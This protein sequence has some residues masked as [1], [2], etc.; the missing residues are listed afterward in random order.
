MV[1]LTIDGRKLEVEEG[2]TVLKAAGDL[3][4]DIPTLCYSD[5]LEPYAGCRL[6][7][8]KV[9]DGD[10][11]YLTTSCNLVATDGM[12]VVTGDDDVRRS[13]KMVLEL[14]L[15]KCPTVEILQELGAEY[16]AD[17]SRFA[18]PPPPEGEE[19][20]EDRCILCG[21]CTRICGQ[22]VKANAIAVNGRGHDSFVSGP[23]E[24][25]SP[26]C[27]ACG[28]C[29]SICPTGAAKVYDRYNRLVIHPELTLASNSAIRFITKQMVPN[30]PTVY[31]EDCIS[32]RQKASGNIDDACR[33]CEESCGKDAI[34]LDTTDEEIQIEV[35]TIIVTTGMQVF[36]PSVIPALGYRR[37][38]NVI[39]G[40]EF[41]FMTRADGMTEGHIKLEDG[42]T[43]ESIAILHCIGSRDSRHHK[44]CSRVCC[45]YSLKFAHLV[46]EHTDAEVYNFYIDMRAFGKGYEAFYM[47]LLD[48]GVH[49]IRGK[50]AEVVQDGDK[51]LVVAEDTLL[52]ATRE[53]PVDMVVLS[54]A[55]EARDNAN[56]VRRIV[57]IGCGDEG[58]FQ[59]M[60]PKLA[61]VATTTD[62]VFIAGA[63]QGPK[64]I[65]D[66][67][68]QGAAAAA[69]ALS[70]IGKGKVEIEPITAVIDEELCSGCRYCIQNCPYTAISYDE[71]KKI[72]VVNSV[73]CKGCGT[74]VA[75][76]PSG[77]SHQKHYSD[78]QIYAEIKGLLQL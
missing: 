42:R 39:T 60:H 35:G 9:G 7:T 77:A 30:A 37:L 48:E 62:G 50:A 17:A 53:I 46:L 69:E 24:Q 26:D 51:L 76:C 36:D 32:F 34:A 19:V 14:L 61:P 64:D 57:G 28:S 16:G 54:T 52:G 23:Y 41:E 78:V 11:A 33:I 12:N 27:I 29:V 18:P 4:I 40:M 10:D 72:S 68:A 8:V 44:Y 70:L 38:P 13:R 49:F 59:E 63:C 58:F 25:P 67:V 21:L 20:E 2:T 75:G 31:E 65:P 3:E 43:P 1:E 55:L 22:R 66:S 47:R 45:M 71:E 56:E 15:A 6:C 73:L 74:C 5:Y